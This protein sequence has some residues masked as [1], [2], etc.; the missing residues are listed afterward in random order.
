[1]SSQLTRAKWGNEAVRAREL[2]ARMTPAQREAA[3]KLN[4][5]INSECDVCGNLW[6]D[7][8]PASRLGKQRPTLLC[9]PEAP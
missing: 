1:V 4:R 9:P 3:I 2:W 6:C 8:R 7:H 5:D